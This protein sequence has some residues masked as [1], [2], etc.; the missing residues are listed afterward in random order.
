M[1]RLHPLT[2]LTA[3]VG[4]IA[5]FDVAMAGVAQ[6]TLTHLWTPVVEIGGTW[7]VFTIYLFLR[8]EPRLAE[9][10]SYV[11]LWLVFSTSAAVLTY[12]AAVA[13]FPLWDTTVRPM[14]LA[15]G[16]DTPTWTAFL[17]RHSGVYGWLRADYF[18]LVIQTSGTVIWLA[19]TRTVGRNAQFLGAAIIGLLLSTAIATLFP[20]IGP[21]PTDS[22]S[23][24][25]HGAI[26]DM[27]VM[28]EG[29]PVIRSIG[30]LQG[31]IQFPSYHTFLAVLITWTNRRLATFWPLAVLNGFML[32]AIPAAGNHYLVDLI[33]G[34]LVAI[35]SI[36]AAAKL[37]PVPVLAPAGV[38]PVVAVV[39]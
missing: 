39:Q 33:G 31:I 23:V 7:V 36:A 38:T 25:G 32:F 17:Q 13:G 29:H 28:R 1:R 18:T 35:V 15:L 11:V 4:L 19:H 34:A 37:F 8:P 6:L 5:A 10:L 3:L 12:V 16:F 20:A 26:N 27:I 24:L 2:V 21:N 14:D 22:P 30:E 9:I